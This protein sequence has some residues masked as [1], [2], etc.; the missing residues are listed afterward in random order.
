MAPERVRSHSRI[1]P[2]ADVFSVGAILHELLSTRRFRRCTGARWDRRIPELTDP[3]VPAEL[4]RLHC[5]LLE[6]NHHKRPAAAEALALLGAPVPTYDVAR[7]LR[8]ICRGVDAGDTGSDQ[9][10]ATSSAATG[11]GGTSTTRT[12]SRRTAT[13]TSWWQRWEPRSF[14]LGLVSATALFTITSIAFALLR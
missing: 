8:R 9:P 1:D 14:T 4:R 11:D 6:P 12:S 13:R 3:N 5:A 2:R 7:E 10:T